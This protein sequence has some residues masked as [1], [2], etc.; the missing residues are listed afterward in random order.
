MQQITSDVGLAVSQAVLAG[1]T[2][3]SLALSP[4]TILPQVQDALL[5]SPS[6]GEVLYSGE[7]VRY[8]GRHMEIR[9]LD[10]IHMLQ[11][12]VETLLITSMSADP[13]LA[14][15][16]EHQRD[17]YM[18]KLTLI[19]S[20]M[21]LVEW[22]GHR[23]APRIRSQGGGLGDVSI[24]DRLELI[25]DELELENERLVIQPDI[26]AEKGIGGLHVMETDCR[27]HCLFHAYGLAN[28]MIS[29]TATG[30]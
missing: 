6:H 20:A 12:L 18:T 16:P 9:D 23:F 10:T 2:I 3:D 24:E 8:G 7:V 4:S 21:Q 19:E 27:G 1:L 28:G 26:L 17:Q 30:K 11:D 5:K 25:A 13:V 22:M 14:P 29:E 15:L